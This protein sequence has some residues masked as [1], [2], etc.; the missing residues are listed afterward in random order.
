MARSKAR[1][2]SLPKKLDDLIEFFETH[3]MGEYW[4]QM[5]EAHFD[6]RTRKRTKTRQETFLDYLGVE[7]QNLLTSFVN[8]RQEFGL[9]DRIDYIYRQPLLRLKVSED[10]SIVPLLCLFVHTHLY[11]SISCILRSHLSEALSATRKAIDAGLT[12]YVLI[13]N[14]DQAERYVN[15][16]KYF[17]F[18]KGNM[19]KEI[20]N[21]HSL[22][23]LAHSLLNIHGLCSQFGSHADFSSFF[24]RLETKPRLDNE[25]EVLVGYFQFPSNTENYRFYYL[26]V[27]QAF[28]L[29]FQIFKTFFDKKLRIIDPDWE[30]A[31]GQLELTLGNLRQTAYDRFASKS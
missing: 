13:L 28:F 10:E 24:H 25:S 16:D 27:L 5:P 4:D 30:H 31:I 18:V 9:F 15:R 3:D 12:A 26:T 22:Y 8:F 11:F 2:N 6:I 29:I 17:Q 20:K 19:E 7:E 23:P 21:D 1:T 14:P